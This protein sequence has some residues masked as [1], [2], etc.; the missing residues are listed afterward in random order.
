MDQSH[1]S[2]LAAFVYLLHSLLGVQAAIDGA[3]TV[4]LFVVDENFGVGLFLKRA[5]AFGMGGWWEGG[6]HMIP[7][8]KFVSEVQKKIP[9]DRK[10]VVA[11]QKGLRCGH[12]LQLHI[13]A[14]DHDQ[15]Y[16]D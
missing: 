12:E 16:E 5:T 8:N 9:K 10:V 2:L 15:Q 13:A 1:E 6:T 3:V 7:N 11:C 14:S 4:P